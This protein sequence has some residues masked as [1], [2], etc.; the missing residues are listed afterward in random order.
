MA[1]HSEHAQ[2]SFE[3]YNSVNEPNS[4]EEYDID[5]LHLIALQEVVE[6]GA[7]T[8]AIKILVRSHNR[9]EGKTNGHNVLF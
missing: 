3:P 9:P 8:I 1:T 4:E 7:E 5:L 6:T 2:C